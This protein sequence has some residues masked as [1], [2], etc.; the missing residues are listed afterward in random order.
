MS[1]E[2]KNSL[3]PREA[4]YKAERE[5]AL[6]LMEDIPD[7]KPVNKAFSLIFISIFVAILILP[8]LT[9]GALKLISPA[10]VEKLSFDT[11]EQRNFATFPETFHPQT[12]TAEVETW[13]NDNLPFRSVLYK[14]QENMINSLEKPYTETLRPALVKLFHGNQQVTPGP[15]PGQLE[16]PFDSTETEP[17]VTETETLPEF[18]TESETGGPS[19]CQHLYAEESVVVQEATCTEYGVIGYEC[20]ECGHIGKKAYSA[21]AE[22]VLL[23]NHPELPRCGEK[24]EETVSCQN[25]DFSETKL[26]EKGHVQGEI[27][28]KVEPS[29][30]TYGYTL[31]GCKD[32]NGEYR[33]ALSDKLY[34][35]DYLPPL[36]HGKDVIE[37]RDKWLF[38]RGNNSESFYKGTNLLSDDELANYINIYQRLK[39][40]CDQ[41]GIQLV[42]AAFP[43]KEQVYSEY[44]PSF[45]IAT[46]TKR[47][48]RWAA[49]LNA[50][51][52]VDVVYPLKELLAAKPYFD[53]YYKYDTHWN[54][55]GGFIGYQA[56]LKALGFETT[57]LI[58]LPS[59]RVDAG[60]G[61]MISIG[62]LSAS[63]YRGDNYNYNITYRP[64][65]TVKT[66]YTEGHISHAESNGHIDLNF[67][68]LS[69]SFR[70][71]IRGFVEKDF[72][73]CFLCHRSDINNPKVIEAI[74]N[75]D[76]LIISA[77][78]RNE[79]D[80]LNTALKIIQY[81]SQP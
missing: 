9:W 32:C 49:Y 26:L 71:A 60:N 5:E 21:K 48:E 70:G 72:T 31:V 43:N 22:H 68:M 47:V 19:A 61:D 46:H 4:S 7:V 28:Q 10:T 74:Q 42:I 64:D 38:Y 45:E 8:M 14:T 11:G 76:V 67:V 20:S 3:H 52:E 17:V 23:S 2:K 36:Y 6:K 15:G 57:D 37:G 59:K 79:A 1:L 40:V 16:N 80:M 30:L 44:M 77:V 39:Q 78:E 35:T 24:Y 63:V 41:K 33:T 54:N 58:N 73:D 12:F 66:L 81:L 27:I 56:L 65:V 51:T 13:F 69:D 18:E 75:A 34:Y 55:A 29:Y 50:N 25:C 53:L 62:S